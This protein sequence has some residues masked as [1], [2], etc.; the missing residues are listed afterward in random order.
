[1]AKIDVTLTRS[2]IGRPKTQ[3]ATVAALG[4]R[5]IR[6]T[7]QHSDSPGLRG[8]LDKVKHLV[9]WSVVEE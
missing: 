6:Q 2:L 8:Q 3:R 5:K 4:L 1:M 7:V 9:T